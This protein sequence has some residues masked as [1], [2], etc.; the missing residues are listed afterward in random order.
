MYKRSF[1]ITF[2]SNTEVTSGDLVAQ[3]SLLLARHFLIFFHCG[4][5]VIITTI[6]GSDRTLELCRS[7]ETLAISPEFVRGVANNVRNTRIRLGLIGGA[8]VLH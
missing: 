1:T 4:P 8:L 6:A 7:W 3:L 2:S 5:P